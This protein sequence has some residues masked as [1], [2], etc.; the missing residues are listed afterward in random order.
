MRHVISESSIY[1]IVILLSVFNTAFS[2]EIHYI[3][4]GDSQYMTLD[5][6]AD[7]LQYDLKDSLDDGEWIVCSEEHFSLRNVSKCNVIIQ[8][9]YCNSLRNGAYVRY[10][11]KGQDNSS[12]KRMCVKSHYSNGVLDGSFQIWDGIILVSWGTYDN[13]KKV[14]VWR[15]FNPISGYTIESHYNSDTILSVVELRQGVIVSECNFEL[16][17]YI[18]YS[19]SGHVIA[20]TTFSADSGAYT[21]KYDGNGNKIA[22]GCGRF[23]ETQVIQ[24]YCSRGNPDAL[25]WRN[26]CGLWHYYDKAGNIIKEE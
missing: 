5:S 6:S 1:T 26:K 7:F 19:D 9:S 20:V 22:E 15:S 14:E 12:L 17:K 10:I 8:A 18:A 4:Y 2:Q 21:T 23:S 24:G 16:N 25:N 11:Q 13:G 3:K